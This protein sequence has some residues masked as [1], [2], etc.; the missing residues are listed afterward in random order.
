LSRAGRDAG[1]L[2]VRTGEGKLTDCPQVRIL[3]TSREP[4][5]ITGE[6]L[7]TVGP[8]T[9]PPDPAVLYQPDQA[10]Y[11]ERGGVPAP[12]I[13]DNASVRLFVQRARA[14][15]PGF[16]VTAA[17][18]PAVTRICRALDGM[19]L[20]IELAAARLRTIALVTTPVPRHRCPRTRS[21]ATSSWP[22]V[23]GT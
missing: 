12:A 2:E 8:L 10:N 15:L 16:E 14:V 22:G 6:A 20:A 18:A 21:D 7:W 4:L 13:D 9:M 23:A 17:N 3:A 5:A 11:N 1:A 19:P